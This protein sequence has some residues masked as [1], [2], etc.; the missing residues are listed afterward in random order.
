MTVRTKRI[1]FL[2]F[3]SILAVA[4]AAASLLYITGLGA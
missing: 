4:I 2:T 3:L 1:L